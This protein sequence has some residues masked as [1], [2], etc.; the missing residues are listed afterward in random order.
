M[1]GARRL[2]IDFQV[3]ELLDD[4]SPGDARYVTL[5]DDVDAFKVKDFFERTGLSVQAIFGT[6]Q[7]ATGFVVRRDLRN[8][9]ETIKALRTLTGLGLKNAKDRVESPKGT[10]LLY[11]QDSAHADHCMQVFR[12]FG[13]T[14][15]ESLGVD[16]M[17]MHELG[18]PTYLE[19][20]P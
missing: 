3:R 13:I 6:H 19:R 7:A 11:T 1:S 14:E 10:V 9:I 18:V 5:G 17:A 20:N 16:V 15:V 2:R 4:G 12:D 8:K